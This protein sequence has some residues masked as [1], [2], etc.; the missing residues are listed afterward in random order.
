MLWAAVAAVP[1][2][3]AGAACVAAEGAEPSRALHGAAVVRLR[4]RQERSR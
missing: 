2:V 4:R 3:A 1:V